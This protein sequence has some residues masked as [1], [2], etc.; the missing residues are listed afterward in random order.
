MSDFSQPFIF[1]ACVGVGALS[2]VLYA[3]FWIVRR[4][5]KNKIIGS[6][7][8][9]FFVALSAAAYFFCLLKTSSGEFRIYTL[10]AY[11]LGFAGFY[12]T[13]RPLSKKI[14]PKIDLGVNKIKEFAKRER[15]KKPKIKLSRKTKKAF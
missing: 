12:M 4:I 1:F 13:L 9:V 3:I 7:C 2:C 14:A 11:F 8:D 5:F 10:L 6:I 15:T